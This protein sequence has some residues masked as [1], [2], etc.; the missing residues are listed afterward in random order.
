MEI[1][2]FLFLLIIAVILSISFTYLFYNLY[3][4]NNKIYYRDVKIDEINMSLEVPVSKRSYGVNI[5]TDAFHFG[6]LPRGAGATRHLNV[7][8]YHNFSVFFYMVKDNSN[9]SEIVGIGPNNFILKPFE[10][11][12][13]NVA[14]QVPKGFKSGNYSGKV[15]IMVRVPFFRERKIVKYI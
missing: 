1:K 7:T 12:T 11:R 5:D 3:S 2:K 13:V 14:A 9:L 15:G 6:R 10:Y 8:N 4:Y